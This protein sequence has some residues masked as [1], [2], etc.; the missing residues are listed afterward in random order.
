MPVEPAQ[1]LDPSPASPVTGPMRVCDIPVMP[2]P[3]M[4]SCSAWVCAGKSE[5]LLTLSKALVLANTGFC[6]LSLSCNSALQM[7]GLDSSSGS[8]F[9]LGLNLAYGLARKTRCSD[10]HSTAAGQEEM[11][12]ECKVYMLAALT[13]L[14]TIVDH[15]SR[16]SLSRTGYLQTSGRVEMCANVQA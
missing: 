9:K 13:R 7:P 1:S 14:V 2:Q 16:K 5:S 10:G 8:H 11:K 6:G 3:I 12:M 15:A 4:V